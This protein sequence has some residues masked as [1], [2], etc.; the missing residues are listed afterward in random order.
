MDSFSDL[1]H[2]WFVRVDDKGIGVETLRLDEV[3]T[4]LSVVALGLR[5]KTQTL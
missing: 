4:L 5:D 2:H 1:K 3:K